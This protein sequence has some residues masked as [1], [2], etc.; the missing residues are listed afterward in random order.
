MKEDEDKGMA[1]RAG[2]A[3]RIANA[4]DEIFNDV[5]YYGTPDK[6]GKN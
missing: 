4:V 6:T 5:L 3:N 1:E 2:I